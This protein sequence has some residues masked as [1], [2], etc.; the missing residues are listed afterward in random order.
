MEEKKVGILS[1]FQDT[2]KI[3]SP[4]NIG[5]Y[6]DLIVAEFAKFAKHLSILT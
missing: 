3:E 4:L 6:V 1:A 5:E 2:I